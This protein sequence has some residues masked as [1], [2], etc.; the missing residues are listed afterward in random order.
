MIQ[1]FDQW[2]ETFAGLGLG[3]LNPV[4]CTV[5]EE[6]GGEYTLEMDYPLDN[7]GLWKRITPLRI[8]VAPVPVCDTPPIDASGDIT[9]GM[10]IW[11]VVTEA[12]LYRK[13][14]RT[15][16]R[17]WLFSLSVNAFSYAMGELINGLR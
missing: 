9:V 16:R 7:E 3:V 10:E 11:A 4:S 6:A 13:F 1:L 2:A 15:V 17:P 8:I 14:A 12:L 5:S